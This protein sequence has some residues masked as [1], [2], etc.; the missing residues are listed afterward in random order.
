LKRGDPGEQAHIVSQS[1]ARARNVTDAVAT[2]NPVTQV[3]SAIRKVRRLVPEIQAVEVAAHHYDAS[4]KP[5]CA[6]DNSVASWSARLLNDASRLEGQIVNEE[7]RD[8]QGLLALVAGQD[9]EPQGKWRIL[10]GLLLIDDLNCQPRA[11]KC[12]RAAV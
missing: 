12:T 6:W 3:V 1:S 10:S 8:A 5:V 7:Q 4:G 11:R 2:Q 9:G